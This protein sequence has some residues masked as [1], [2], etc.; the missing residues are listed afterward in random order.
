MWEASVVRTLSRSNPRER[1]GGVASD[2]GGDVVGVGRPR[3]GA[4]APGCARER[5][6]RRRPG[7]GRGGGT[8]FP[9]RLRRALRR[10][11]ARA[12]RARGHPRRAAAGRVAFRRRRQLDRARRTAPGV[13]RGLPVRGHLGD[14]VHQH[15]PHQ[16]AWSRA[17]ESAG[18][19]VAYFEGG[20]CSPGR[21][22]SATP[23]SRGAT[24]AE[25][26]VS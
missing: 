2:K 13:P 20:S 15:P 17:G 14:A 16:A 6:G 23:A 12:F 11:L 26:T 18:I 22:R 24:A 21:S 4:P 1:T 5:R 8:P 3:A 19:S 7:P 25:S 10:P 9:P